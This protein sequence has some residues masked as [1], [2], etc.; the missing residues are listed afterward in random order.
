[1]NLEVMEGIVE[2]H[3]LY[4]EWALGGREDEHLGGA[5]LDQLK[6]RLTTFIHLDGNLTSLKIAKGGSGLELTVLRGN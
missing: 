1:M 5:L 4:R 6:E 2:I 3:N